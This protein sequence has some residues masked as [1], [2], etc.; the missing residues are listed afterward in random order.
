M[1]RKKLH[2]FVY[3]MPLNRALQ[4]N[5]EISAQPVPVPRGK[6]RLSGSSLKDT[7]K[8]VGAFQQA[9][10]PTI[11]QKRPADGAAVSDVSET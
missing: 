3:Y 11:P 1:F 4:T 8:Q 6:K 10:E 5:K 2:V 7:K 9:S